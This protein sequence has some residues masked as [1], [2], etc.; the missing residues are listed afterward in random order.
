ML[1]ALLDY[2]Q[3][4]RLAAEPGFKLKT[5]PWLLVFSP[6]GEFLGVQDLRG[7]DRKRRGR[8][9]PLCPDLTQPELITAGAGARHFLVDALEVVVLLTSDGE[10]DQKLSAKHRRF[11]KLLEQASSSV[12]ELGTIA[13]RLGDVVSLGVIRARLREHKAKPAELAT[14]AVSGGG[15]S[16]VIVVERDDWHEWW[17][18]FRGKLGAA[19]GKKGLGKSQEPKGGAAPALRM[20]CLLSGELVEPQS[21]HNKITGLADVGGHAAGDVL[22]GFDK[23]AFRSFGLSH[24]ANAAMSETMVKTYTT[25][26]NDLIKRRSQRLAGVKVIYWYTGR[27]EEEDD[28]LAA[29]LAGF[30]VSQPDDSDEEAPSADQSRLQYRAESRAKRLLTAIRAGERADLKN[31]RY[32]ALTLSANSGRV[33]I[34]DWMEGAFE[35][36]LHVV[37]GWFDDLS[38]VSRDGKRIIWA[39]KFAAV[40]AAPVRDLKDAP[41]SLVA[42]LWRCALKEQP[43]PRQ[44]M[45]QTLHR[46]RLD[47]IRDEPPCHARFGLLK[48]FCNREARIPNMTAELNDVETRAAYVC[49]RIMAILARI[50]KAAL[51]DV[52]LGGVQRYYA[53]ASATPALVLG[54]LV[55]T[56]QIAHLPKIRSKGVQIWFENQLRDTWNKLSHA[57]PA[58][59]TLEEQTLFAMG[60]Y[61]QRAKPSDRTKAGDVKDTAGTSE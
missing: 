58:V 37:N 32:Y 44:V 5:V 13:T 54:R 4:E 47:L 40:L 52:C 7:D 39:H 6:S 51:G 50:Q 12:A 9:F 61:H 14:F 42:A 53:A 25:A 24:A 22:A 29:V 27:V 21:T 18:S 11:V 15:G 8:D 43:I 10:I 17:R 59:L 55:R 49:G 31:F 20:P 1:H 16:A 30:E 36:L 33:V 57:P 2:A 35:E 41:P 48:A 38:I 45:A 56:A 34:R 3:R 19:R 60:Y 46:V 26:L 28:V 23:E